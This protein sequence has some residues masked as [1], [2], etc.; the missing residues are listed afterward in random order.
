MSI[1]LQTHA[2]CHEQSPNILQLVVGSLPVN[3][4]LKSWEARRVAGEKVALSN[5]WY[6]LS[7]EDYWY[8]WCLEMPC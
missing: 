2:V 8:E 5:L 7:S 1:A 4:E 3:T 6:A